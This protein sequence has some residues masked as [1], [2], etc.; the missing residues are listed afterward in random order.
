MSALSDFI[1]ELGGGLEKVPLPLG[2]PL[3]DVISAVRAKTD[4]S[5]VFE[6]LGDPKTASRFHLVGFDPQYLVSASGSTLRIERREDGEVF[7]FSDENPYYAL[8]KLMPPAISERTYCGGLVGY[9]SFDSVG[10]FEESLSVKRSEHFDTFKFGLFLDGV[11]YDQVTD[12]SYYFHFGENRFDQY[13]ARIGA[14]P[15]DDT[16]EVRFLGDTLDRE[17]HAGFVDYV[18]RE[19]S[20]GNVF[21]CELGFRSNYAINGDSLEIYRELRSVNPSPHMYLVQFGDQELIGASP[22]LL[23]R[24]TDREVETYPLAGTARRSPDTTEDRANARALLNDEKELAEH[25]MLVDLHRNDLGRVCEIGSVR[26]R[27]LMEIKKFSHVQ[28][29]SS[30]IV[31]LLESG[32]DAF[33]ALAACFPAGTLTGAPKIEAIRLLD[34]LEQEGR[35]PYGG[36]VGYFA[37]NGDAAFAIPI[38]S[39]FRHGARGYVQTCGGNVF[40]SNAHDEFEELLGKLAAMKS[41][42]RKFEVNDVQNSHSR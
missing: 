11:V 27:D 1:P 24:L 35:G 9:L 33:S 6:S 39:L 17:A 23:L 4:N 26:I 16:V 31:G 20:Q 22:E 2:T 5:F 29:I 40:D 28:H 38:R 10:Y 7:E 25:R 12:E 14:G 34:V 3:V 18:K 13:F 41:V 36:A 15:S 21:Q 8:R 32:E 42:L 37:F 30:E 19:I